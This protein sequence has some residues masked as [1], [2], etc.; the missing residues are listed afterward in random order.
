M[1]V[2]F[3]PPSIRPL[4]VSSKD[5]FAKRARDDKS[6]YTDSSRAP[7]LFSPGRSPYPKKPRVELSTN[8]PKPEPFTP[9]AIHGYK[10]GAKLSTFAHLLNDLLLPQS[11]EV[12]SAK[13]VEA[14]LDDSASYAFHVSHPALVY[15]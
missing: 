9:L 3:K 6:T 13:S 8:T 7:F 10:A 14:I 12:Q 2:E 1:V 4:I 5:L 15:F 11:I